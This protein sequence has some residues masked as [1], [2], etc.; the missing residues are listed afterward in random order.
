[1]ED[2]QGGYHGFAISTFPAG[3]TAGSYQDPEC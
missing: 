2:L 3:H 1:M